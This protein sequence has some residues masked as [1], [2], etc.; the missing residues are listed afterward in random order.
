MAGLRI[1][2]VDLMAGYVEVRQKAQFIR[3]R[4]VFGMPKSRRSSREIPILDRR[5]LADLRAFKM[6]HPRS[7]EADALFWPGRMPGSH[8]IDYDRVWHVASFR[9]SHFKPALALAKLLPM[10]VHDLRHTAA[11]LWLAAGF[12][13]YQV[14]RWL[15]HANVVTTDTIYS[16]LY[17]TDYSQHMEKFERFTARRLAR[18]VTALC[19]RR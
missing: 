3:G 19:G 12:P 2:D 10:R 11:S 4:W 7:G 17:P 18:E 13:P 14:S 1:R 8:F 9:S 15:G 16:H 5:L 6:Q